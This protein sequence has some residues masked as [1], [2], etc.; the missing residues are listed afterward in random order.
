MEE[1]WKAGG[2]EAVLGELLPLLHGDALTVNGQ[3]VAENAHG[4]TT[5]DR[6]VIRSLD[7]PLQ[8]GP[9]IAVVRGS[10]APDGAVIKRSAASPQ[11]LAHRG[12]AFVFEDIHDLGARIADPDLPITRD[13]V[14]VL[15][16]GG[17]KGAPGMPEWGHIP[18]PQ[19]LIDEGVRDAVRISD[20]RMSGTS[21][22]TVVLH[23]APE[24]A[25]GGPLA[26]VR[27][28]DPIV[29]DVDAGRLDLDLDPAEIERRLAEWTPPAR[30]YRRGY[31]ALYLDHVL[32]AD[33]GADFDFLTNDEGER[34]EL[35]PLGLMR[36]WVGH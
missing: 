15:K 1:F 21:S 31:G 10:L 9:S 11:L 32:Q 7:D 29:L 6:E 4:R 23:V 14:I 35:L 12:P 2:T 19:R 26:I 33:R 16:R 13:H 8:P 5:D 22:G 24:A 27:T 30:Q 25:A 17:P 34:P 36:G 3:T 28:D 20:S 18:L